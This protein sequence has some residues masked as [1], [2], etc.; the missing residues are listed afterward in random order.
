MPDLPIPVTHATSV[1][2]QRKVYV[3]GG[4]TP[5]D[6]SD[7]TVHVFNIDTGKWTTLPPAPQCYSEAIAINNNLVLIGGRYPSTEEVTNMVSTWLADKWTQTIPPMIVKRVRPGVLLLKN[8]LFVFGG[9]SE[10]RN[11]LL[12]SF[13][14]LD[15]TKNQWSI[16]HGVLPQPLY[17]LKLGV[18]GDTVILTSA[19]DT[20]STPTTK[21]WKIPVQ[22]LEDSVTNS[23]SQPI[24]WTRIADT[25]YS[26]SSLLTNSKQPVC[27]GGYRDGQP[28]T[29]I[30]RYTS[31]NWELIGHLS[32]PCIRPS[33][34]TINSSSF[35]VLGGHTDPYKPS[36]SLHNDVE[37]IMY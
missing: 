13:E 7:Q 32:Q 33:V 36:E 6:R 11:T 37:L 20:I 10:D 9:V 28:T 5:G 31:H 16:G 29:S 35:L 24:Q 23:S 12:D 8:F 26:G 34:V 2:L 19:L 3:A 21:S 18:F 1:I 25:P 17:L 15:I 30:Y 27:V 22:V 14:V 4:L